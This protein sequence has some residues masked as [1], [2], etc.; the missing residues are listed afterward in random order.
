M[1]QCLH[2]GASIDDLACSLCTNVLD[3]PIEFLCKHCVCC[4]CCIRLLAS[5]VLFISCPTCKTQHEIKQTN[6]TAPSP[7]TIK[8]LKQLVIH[9]EKKNCNKAVYLKDLEAHLASNC[10]QNIDVTHSITLDCILKQ[11]TNAP[12]TQV[13]ME[14][15]GHV[16]RRQ[17]L[18]HSQSTQGQAH[19]RL[20]TGG[21]VSNRVSYN[22]CI[23]VSYQVLL[24]NLTTNPLLL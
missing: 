23:P 11:P 10:K 24:S 12:P 8:L 7:L 5:H 19:F 9:C 22:Y 14:A 18:A 3:E 6:F 1:Y 13:E 2:G 17:L 20:P 16:I 21:C 15:A 4:S